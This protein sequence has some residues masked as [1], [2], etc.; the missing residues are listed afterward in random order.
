VTVTKAV[1]HT[2]VLVDHLCSDKSPST[3][4]LALQRFFCYTTVFQAIELFSL[5]RTDIEMDAIN[6]AMSAMKVL[7]LN[8]KNAR[9]YGELVRDNSG[10]D[11][12]TL[13]IAGLCLE[14]RLPI[15]T[16]K[17][18]H[19]QGIRGLTVIPASEVAGFQPHRRTSGV[20]KT[21]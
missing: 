7:G 16:G 4:R 18:G 5:G 11:R 2:D 13:M 14:S 3:L 17:V 21:L 15:I 10:K 20:R 19:F 1:I 12:W 9:R 6:D 8:A